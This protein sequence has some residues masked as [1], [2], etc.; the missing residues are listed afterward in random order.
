MAFKELIKTKS[1]LEDIAQAMHDEIKD[2][3]TK[4]IYRCFRLLTTGAHFIDGKKTCWT[5]RSCNLNKEDMDSGIY[6][7]TNSDDVFKHNLKQISTSGALTG[8]RFK[9]LQKEIPLPEDKLIFYEKNPSHINF[10]DEEF[11]DFTK[12][13]KD[14]KITRWLTIEQK[15]VVN[16]KGGIKIQS[17]PFFHISYAQGYNPLDV[18]RHIGV[19][20]NSKEEMKN[21]YNIIKYLPDPTPDKRI[22]N[23][24]TFF[25]ALNEIY[26]VSSKIEC[27]NL[28][29]GIYDIVILNGVPIH[30]IFGHHFEEPIRCLNFGESN[31]FRI[32]QRLKNVN[33][34]LKDDANTTIAEFRPIG[35]TYFDAY[36]RKRESKTH[37][38]NGQVNEF[39]GSEYADL[40]KLNDYMGI[41]NGSR[42]GNASQFIDGMFP[43]SRMSCTV[44]DGITKNLDLEEKLIMIP[45]SGDTDSDLK[46]F[47]LTSHE[48]YI[49][50]NSEL[51]R[52]PPVQV[53]G[54]ILNALSNLELL[55]DH[56][57]SIGMC[58]K[59]EPICFKRKAEVP[60][61]QFVRAQLWREQQ[62]FP[63]PIPESYIQSLQK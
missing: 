35:F 1:D 15:I 59:P 10:Y 28:R 19:A 50:N 11:Q 43:Q 32:M 31:P 25:K 5:N 33:L 42:P 27:K 53:T 44:L 58:A 23:A 38:E 51:Q 20:C 22:R 45:Q 55:E 29:Q 62:V 17:I 18:N 7:T 8:C 12:E 46:T 13:H 16:S 26:N 21:L 60:V 34:L 4:V 6:F 30:E 14:V 49:L 39:L 3:K 24:N 57:Y 56:S 2:S 41:G 37:I 48:C 36:G 61:S 52:I 54:G 63:L 9:F 40:E 47:R